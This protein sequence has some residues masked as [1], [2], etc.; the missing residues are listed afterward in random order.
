MTIA[1]PDDYQ[2]VIRTLNC[3]QLL[4][5]HQVLTFHQ[6]ETDEKVLAEWFKDADIIVL[7]RTRTKITAS[8]LAQLPKLKLI[9]Q[10]GKNAGHIDVAACTKNG[11]AVV[12]GRGNPIATAELTWALIMNGLRQIPQAIEGM[13]AGKWQTNIGRR[14]FG[15]TI[16]I[17]SY[18]KI[19]KRVANYAK[20]FG[21][22]VLVWG[23]ENS[24]QQ[25]K[26]DGF[27]VANSKADFFKNSDVV[28]IHIRLKA[29]T[30]G[31]I[32]AADLAFMKPSALLV[33]TSRAAL[34]EKEA[35][36]TALKN[37]RPGFAAIDVYDEEPIFDKNHP[38]L[39]MSNVICTPH[40]GYVEMESY[41]LYFS[42]AFQNVLDFI[43][44]NPN[45]FQSIG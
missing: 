11:V 42:I 3:F 15:K 18:G 35:L 4:K 13:K 2:H 41:E 40:L 36:L 1:I 28:S 37:G 22:N 26:V 7:T 39:K 20:A 25:A 45:K 19:G 29:E 31:I 10:T 8:L 17:W 24:T 27:E 32:K 43:K 9:S 30:K 21:A 23:R 34:I 5:D 16:G 44:D 6:Y 33:N 14:V 12:E 38:F